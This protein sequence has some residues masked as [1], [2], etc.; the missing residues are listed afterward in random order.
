MPGMDGIQLTA[1]LKNHHD[2]AKSVVI[3]ITAAEWS[4]VEVQARKA[5][6]DKFLPKPL[7]PSSIADII[8]EALGINHKRIEE[9]TTDISG[10]FKGRRVLLVED[11]EIN[12]DIVIALL[13][14]ANIEIDCAENGKE[15]LRMFKEAPDK[16]DMIFMDVQMP[17]M[18]GYEA[19]RHI[20]EILP[21]GK[22]IP[23]VAMTANVFREDI[24]RC[25][26]AGMN[27]HV[28]KPLDFNEVLKKLQQYIP[29]QVP[30]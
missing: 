21:R 28:G 30:R 3:M 2:P 11:V 17:E 15:A 23:I 13:E 1:E 29:C 20:R 6:V 16:Y 5:G 14:P 7:F 18:D 4:S 9:T 19:T 27:D 25:L 26:E 22:N 8:S 12:R 10:L 24:A